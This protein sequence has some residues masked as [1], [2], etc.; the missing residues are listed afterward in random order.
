MSEVS[1]VTSVHVKEIQS[2]QYNHCSI[3][4][5]VEHGILAGPCLERALDAAFEV[6]VEADEYQLNPNALDLASSY[7]ICIFYFYISR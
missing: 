2:S 5:L 6:T 3:Q 1:R 7:H 4:S